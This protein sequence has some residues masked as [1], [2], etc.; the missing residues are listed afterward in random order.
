[1]TTK[2]ETLLANPRNR[3]VRDE[4]LTK[5]AE[6]FETRGFGQSRIQDIAQTLHLSRSALYHYFDSKDTILAALVEEHVVERIAGGEELARD[7]H[8]PASDRMREALQRTISGRFASASRLRVLDRIASE[9]PE[10]LR[11]KLDEGRRRVLE[12]YTDIIADGVASGEFRDIDTRTA[13]LAVLGIASWTSWWYSPTGRKTPEELIET[14]VDVALNGL[15]AHD[16]HTGSLDREALFTRIRADLDAIERPATRSRQ[17][18]ME[19]RAG[20]KQFR[21][22]ANNSRKS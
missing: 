2:S 18:A 22:R 10:N 9:M 6:V 14:L 12:Y 20:P 1:M 16:R 19:D 11:K 5:A 3:L 17:G 8:K 7:K 13:A 4:I 21:E 15:L